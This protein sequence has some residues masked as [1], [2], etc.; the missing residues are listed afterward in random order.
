MLAGKLSGS[1]FHQPSSRTFRQ[2]QFFVV[3]FR[4][5]I[6]S[7]GN[8]LNGI[9]LKVTRTSFLTSSA[10]RQELETSAA[11]ASVRVDSRTRAP[12]GLDSGDS[13]RK[14]E[15]V[16]KRFAAAASSVRFDSAIKVQFALNLASVKLKEIATEFSSLPLSHDLK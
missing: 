5:E 11:V 15:S 10:I 8:L 16:A 7:V 1:R 9:F 12:A 2:K 4:N 13:V 3:V 6:V 14:L